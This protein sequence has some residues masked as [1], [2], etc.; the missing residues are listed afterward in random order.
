MA[1]RK[2]RK[3]TRRKTGSDGDPRWTSEL[4]PAPGELRILQAFLN[5]ADLA[6]G[7]DLAVPKDLTGWLELWGL[8]PAGLAVT[9]EEVERAREV[10]EAMRTM[11]RC[12]PGK[13]PKAAARVD[14]AAQAAPLF[15]RVDPES[16]GRLEQGADSVD[17]ALARLCGILVLAQADGTWE[18]LKICAAE[19]CRAAFY[20]F[21]R[22][23]SAVWCTTRCGGRKSGLAYRW[24]NIDEIRQRDRGDA[25]YRRRSR[26]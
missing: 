11:V 22:N 20:D 5:T 19:T 12:E 24:R 3:K 1:P 13:A 17:G 10:R 2:P 8:A 15:A 26:R 25:I 7:R 16:R 14:A 4:A 18:R 6:A 21:S 9:A 23:R